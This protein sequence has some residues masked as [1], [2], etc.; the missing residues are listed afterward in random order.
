[1]GEN[2]TM[3]TIIEKQTKPLTLIC[4]IKRKHLN[5]EKLPIWLSTDAEKKASDNS[6]VLLECSM[7]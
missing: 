4:G 5:R 1:M 6:S 7:T 3:Q 2:K